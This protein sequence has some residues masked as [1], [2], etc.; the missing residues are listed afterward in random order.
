M[1]GLE[2]G[3]C[4]GHKHNYSDNEISAIRLNLVIATL[5]NGI[6]S[7]AER[8]AF[9]WT[10]SMPVNAASLHDF[11]DCGA[12]LALLLIVAYARKKERAWDYAALASNMLVI[13]TSY[14]AGAQALRRTHDPHE[15]AMHGVWMLAAINLAANYWMARRLGKGL[16]EAE[17]ASS[18]HFWEDA[19]SAGMI[20]VISAIPV[21]AARNSIDAWLAVLISLFF[22]LRA[23]NKASDAIRRITAPAGK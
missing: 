7:L 18:L 17:K 2:E 14:V 4:H 9:L 1:H 15:I 5:G 8:F 20:L 16:S 21:S 12:S 10:D 11:A 23:G 22:G 19:A 6:L 3:C 13:V